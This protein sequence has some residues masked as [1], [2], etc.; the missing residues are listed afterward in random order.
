MSESDKVSISQV[1]TGT[2]GG[3]QASVGDNNFL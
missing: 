1:N 2:S 3:M